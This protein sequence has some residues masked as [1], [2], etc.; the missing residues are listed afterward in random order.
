M[1]SADKKYFSYIKGINT[2]APLVDWPDGYSIDEQNFDLLIDGSRRRRPG[3]AIESTTTVGE[4]GPVV[5]YEPAITFDGSS[6]D[7]SCATKPYRWSDAGLVSSNNLVVL[8]VGYKVHLWVEPTSGV[9]GAPDWEIDLSDHASRY[10]DSYTLDTYSS[11]KTQIQTALCDFTQ[12]NGKLVIANKYVEPLLVAYE[13]GT[14]DITEL[15][16]IER[17]L[18]GVDDGVNVST[19]P[20]TLTNSHEYNLTNRGWTPTNITTFFASAGLYPSK[21]MLQYIGNRNQ[22][23]AGVA[24]EQGTKL[25]TPAALQKE[26][27]QN[28]SAPQGHNTREVFNRRNSFSSVLSTV[29]TTHAITSVAVTTGAVDQWRV[30]ITVAAAHGVLLGDIITLSDLELK[31]NKP[32]GDKVT[33]KFAGDYTVANVLSPTSFRIVVNYTTTDRTYRN[34]P[35]LGQYTNRSAAVGSVYNQD[36]SAIPIETRFT[37]VVS[38]A[39]RVFFAGCSDDRISNRVYYSQ[40][41]EDDGD[42]EKCYQES[43]PTSEFISDL[44]PDDGGYVVLPEAGAV[45]NIVPFASSLIVFASNSIWEIGPGQQGVFSATGYSVKKLSNV[46][47][48]SPRSIL[49]AADTPVYWGEDGIYA[50]GQDQTTGYS[51]STN[52]TQTVIN[53]L[54]SSIRH[55][56]KTR[57]KGVY[58]PLRQRAMWLYNSRL[59][60]P[61]DAQA[62]LTG[63]GMVQTTPVTPV[64]AINDVDTDQITF[65]SI[66]IFDFRLKAWTRWTLGA[67]ATHDVRDIIA[68]PTS[69]MSNHNLRLKVVCQV[70]GTNTFN[71]CEF[72]DETLYYDNGA[73]TEAFLATGPDSVEEPAKFK[74]A[75][76]VH[77]FM[78]RIPDSKMQMQA[79]WD[80]A[81]GTNSS[82]ITRWQEVY[83]ETRPNSDSYGLIVTK[84]KI[85]GRG[86]NL[87]LVF[88]SEGSS[89][90]WLDGW[91]TKFDASMRT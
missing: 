62:P 12:V 49:N 16:L 6:V 3:L 65:D 70:K 21:N 56:E 46:G 9:L 53:G 71:I 2:E 30:D 23:T 90:C 87:F 80:W 10:T 25:F 79:R 73:S 39:S 36:E 38:F 5:V 45:F 61:I 60:A 22:T 41:V 75:P 63:V 91:T 66:L 18:Q 82:K 48:V 78:R 42:I 68:M 72:V 67:S 86:R 15:V 31:F 20:T 81:R 11:T 77:V 28:M 19:Q 83:R 44:L 47:C 55:Q 58:D 85:P 37:S 57:V 76:Y 7:A 69:F 1:Q 24:P 14:L 84:N 50:I 4:G 59:T 52:V 88:K 74:N 34:C 33:K 26:L 51:T 43:D 35:S 32:H 17:D 40:I 54:F 64:G 29:T 27:F 89:P 8:Q 13:S